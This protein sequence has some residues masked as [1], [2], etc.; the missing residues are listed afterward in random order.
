MISIDIYRE[1]HAGTRHF[2]LDVQLESSAKRIALFGPSGAGKSL[3][4]N[5]IAGLLRPDRGRIAV[6]GTTL[7]DVAKDVFLSP[8]QRRLGY[9]QQ[10]Y[11]LF[12]HL[13]VA[14]NIVF[15]LS[16]GWV[17]P[18]GRTLPESAQRWVG[19]FEL[20]P[21]LGSYPS[22]ISGGQKQRVALARA[23]AVR[24]RLLLLDEPLAALDAGLRHR[25]RD[26]LAMLQQ[27]LDIPTI[28]ITHDPAD[29][30]TLA[31]QVFRIRDGRI[32]DVCSP[33]ELTADQ[34]SAPTITLEA[35]KI[36]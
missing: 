1:L 14:Q 23:L 20:E 24:P 34:S 8:Q 16:K 26:E 25:M 35:L 22:E 3:T 15:G 17:N 2:V 30:E 4:I 18:R 11:G 9:L 12:P 28:L 36:A 10:D 32:V 31:E 6:N 7:L 27:R 29:V 21:I 33:A 19:A 5:A 13:T